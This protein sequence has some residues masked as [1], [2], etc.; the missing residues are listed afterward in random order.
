LSYHSNN[1]G[2]NFEDNRDSDD[3]NEEDMDLYRIRQFLRWVLVT[4]NFTAITITFPSLLPVSHITTPVRPDG[5]MES[6]DL[7][8]FRSNGHMVPLGSN[9][10]SFTGWWWATWTREQQAAARSEYGF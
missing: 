8:W 10:N 9:T 3:S 1:Y 5:S 6:K 2:Y 4:H 7:A